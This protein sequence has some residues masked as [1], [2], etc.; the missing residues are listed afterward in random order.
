MLRREWKRDLDSSLTLVGM[1]ALRDDDVRLAWYADVL[2]P[3]SD[4][5]CE[6]AVS[7]D[8]IG[9]GDV[10]RG[11]LALVGS[12]MPTDDSR[13]VRGLMGDMMY[14]L[15]AT[16]RC[17]AER[18]VGAVIAAA[19]RE[20]RPVIV[21]AYSLGSL[22][23]YGYL[24]TAEPQPRTGDLRLVTVGSPLG[25]QV[26]REIVFGDTARMLRLPPT[27]AAVENVYDPSDFLSAPLE[28][29]LSAP[30]VRDDATHAGER[31]DPHNFTRYLRDRATGAAVMRALC[32][33]SRDEYPACASR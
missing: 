15:D 30:S 31:D 6:S 14:A 16:K 2:D 29:V 5:L 32:A 12:T 4:S 20:K 27:V 3:E 10:A 17:A 1:P 8:S 25:V 23:T 11:F 21:I 33:S 18:R 19:Q 9:F 7:E 24:R 26:I 22:V 28:G 13:E